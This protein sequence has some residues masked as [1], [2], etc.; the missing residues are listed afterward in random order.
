MRSG[1][2][3]PSVAAGYW[4]KPEISD[5][6]FRAELA[7]NR[8][9]K[10]LR[11]GDLGFFHQGELFITG[12]LKDMIIVRG[13][14]RY[15]QD[16][17]MTVE[18]ADRRLRSGAAAAFAVDIDGRERLI[19]VSEVQR[20]VDDNWNEVIDAVR[21][22]VTLQH[23]LPPD[24]VVLVRTGFDSQ[25]RRVARSNAT[26][27]AK[28][29]WKARSK[30][31]PRCT[32][33]SETSNRLLPQTDKELHRM[34]RSA[35]SIR[36]TPT[37]TARTGIPRMK[38]VGNGENPAN[39]KHSTPATN[40]E[41]KSLGGSAK[42]GAQNGSA[43]GSVS[44]ELNKVI[45]RV[46]FHVREIAKERATELTESTNIVEL[47]LD[48]LERMEIIT[49][50]ESE[51]EGHFPEENPAGQSKTIQQVSEAIIQYMSPDKSSSKSDVPAEHYRFDRMVEYVQL[52]RNK[53]LLESTG[54]PNPYFKAH[55]GVTRDTAMIDGRELISFAT[56]NYI[57]MSG[58][59]DV[60][61]GSQTS[62]RTIWDEC[63]GKPS[64]FR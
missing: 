35:K 40:G 7:G 64:G 8:P 1:F 21:R 46:K 59:P 37:V 20:G 28:D 3:S 41:N 5:Q 23:E 33:G 63:L 16:I 47:G 10:Y 30:P 24:G 54:I 44:S 29:F 62:R 6:T 39:G 13:V 26:H 9:G 4:N 53:Q 51:F 55:Q 2:P 34:A 43:N 57:G 15:P 58:D 49:A 19:V 52:Q 11:S 12:R 27:V 22:D 42:N 56:Y 61:E 38:Q 17:E 31:W 48:S 45:D 32:G 25:K 14:N 18:Q 50:L 60:N 36:L